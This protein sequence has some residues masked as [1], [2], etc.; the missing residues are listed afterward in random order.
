MAKP[1]SAYT[2]GM[3]T[4]RPS[5]ETD[6]APRAATLIARAFDDYNAR[7]SD[8]TRRAR[9]RFERR[10]WKLA[11]QDA[12]ARIDLY[13]ICVHE[14]LARLETLLD[15]RVRSRPLWRAI[16][17]AFA[18]RIAAL[19]DRE[20]YKT[21]Y[22]S[23]VR[24]FF[25]IDGVAPDLEFL[26][27]EIVP[28]G[29][30]ACPGELQH[31]D[32]GA[33]G[34]GAEAVWRGLFERLGYANGWADLDASARAVAQALRN[35]GVIGVSVLRTPFYRERRAYLV[36]RAHG[37]SGATYPVV[38]ALVSEPPGVR[39]DAVLVDDQ[40][41]SILFGFSRSHFHADLARVGDAVAFLHR[42]LPRKPLDELF[43]MVGRIKQGKTERYRQVFR[44]LAEHPDEQLVIA[45]GERG[46]VMAVFTPPGYPLVFKL[47]RDRFA[48]P[49]D[50]VRAEVEEKYRLVFRRDRIG[51]LIDAQE[52]L[53]LRFPKRQFAPALL[54][55]LLRECAQTVEVEGEE[56]L[57]RH[58]YIERR[59]RPLDLYV[60]ESD[61]A[62]AE[63]ALLD[64]GQAIKDLARSNL[65]PGD[66]LLKNFGVTR[67]GRV[68]FYD[69]D[70]LCLVEECRF[71]AVPP[72][73]DEDET[74]PL[75]EWLYAGADDVFPELFPQFLGVAP[76]LRERLR[77]VHGEIFDPAW[78]REVQTR[79]AAGEHFDV[80][81]YPASARLPG[82]GSAAASAEP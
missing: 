61:R 15:D 23:L 76:A 27:F 17:P 18:A 55:E 40:Q 37:A 70:E 34:A 73:R 52:F 44:H 79:L 56:V 36:G 12:A 31:H 45:D 38:V 72:M 74:R 66:L 6:A 47:I 1:A 7:F 62:A 68:L 24:R 2:A 28:T 22:N 16:R 49:K 3:N 51:R 19:P 58:C 8:I 30:P 13:E 60:R 81:P 35:R 69:Y 43:T 39:A 32:F 80:P 41:I 42:L 20:L 25:R 4:S 57:I 78:W 75:D 77:A 82:P 50:T 5:R 33:E 71:R 65:F 29:D 10:D 14:T 53:R 54:D 48:Y 9:R 11:P 63:R 46:M 26:A 21:F 67:H 59:L 64:Y